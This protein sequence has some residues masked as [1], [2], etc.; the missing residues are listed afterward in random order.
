MAM[1]TVLACLLAAAMAG[2]GTALADPI[3]VN[4]FS[5]EQ[6]GTGK[7][8]GWDNPGADIPGWSSDTTAADSGVEFDWPGS[9]EGVWA[10]FL[11]AADSG[12][13]QLT[14]RTIAA[15][16]FFTLKVDLQN[17]YS[18]V[19][20]SF[21]L[22]LYYDDAGTRVPVASDLVVPGSPWSEFSLSFA[23]GSVPAAIGR[24]IGIELDNVTAGDSWI[25]LDNVRLDVIPEPATVGLMVLGALALRLRRRA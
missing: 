22:G 10:G 3:A 13:W 17:N 4:N 21:Q 23:G 6:P 9:T 5:F 2:M 1:K 8:K 25:G 20:P 19:T 12:I 11:M 24:Q 18:A 15:S 7:I 16:D 14:G